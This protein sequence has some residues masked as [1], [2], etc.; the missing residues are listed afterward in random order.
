MPAKA[1]AVVVLF[2]LM[3]YWA[4]FLSFHV[5]LDAVRNASPGFLQAEIDRAIA[6]LP[7][8]QRAG[9][10]LPLPEVGYY[11]DTYKSPAV[12]IAGEMDAM[13]W[14]ANHTAASDKF[15]ADI[16]GAE[17]IM[18]MTTRRSTVGG[19]WANAPDPVRLMTDTDR[20]YKTDDPAEASGLAKALN[21]TLVYLPRRRLH[22][23]WWLSGGDYNASK[24]DD[25]RYFERV[26]DDAGVTIYRIL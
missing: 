21:A 5:S 11:G 22:T 10:D 7:P 18:G 9:I 16:F 13:P 17:V 19:D 23:G 1:A 2:G 12:V 4:Y 26:Y 3:V 15:V 8:D 24:F 6:R 20:I 25:G 14:I